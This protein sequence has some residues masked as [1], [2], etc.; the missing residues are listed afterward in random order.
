MI[1]RRNLLQQSLAVVSLGM[2]VPSVFSKAVVAAAEEKSASVA[3][4]TLVV[5]QMGGGVDGLNTVIPYRDPLYRSSRPALAIPEAEVLP[6]DERIAFHP[7][8]PGMKQLF[9]AG[10]LAVIEGVGYP[11]PNFSHFESMDIWQSADPKNAAGDGWLGRYFEGLTDAQ[12]HPLIGLNVG[13]RLASSFE[14]SGAPVPSIETIETFALQDSIYDPNPDKRR[15]SLMKLYDVYQPAQWQYAALLDTTLDTAYQSSL[16]LAAAH[17][18]YRPAVEYPQSGLA[19]GLRLLAELIDSGE[20]GT[21]PLRVGHV[22]IGGFDTHTNQPNNLA[23]LLRETSEAL[24]AFVQ[25]IAAHGRLD[26]VLLMTWSEFGRR[27]PENAQNG[28][29]HGAAGPMFVLGSKVKGGFYG[30]P[31]NL[32]DL[33]NDNMKF[34]TDFRSVYAT[35]LERWLEA[36]ADDILGGRFPQLDF[37]SA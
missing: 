18:A 32:R 33:E 29:D 19:S 13:R 36:P 25:D 35:V 21:T 5:V 27:V 28:T 2:A 16:D 3:G 1:S 7:A 6:I 11:E 26:D 15:T 34:T 23:R 9:E 37:V 20:P 17:A 14:T 12:G 8:W 24:H 4:K 22:S 31:P 30:E 10:Q